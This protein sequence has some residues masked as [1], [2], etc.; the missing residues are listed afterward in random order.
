MKEAA[1]KLIGT[2]AAHMDPE[3]GEVRAK[4]KHGG[5]LK[6]DGPELLMVLSTSCKTG[7]VASPEGCPRMQ[8]SLLAM[9][10]EK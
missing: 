1:A 5:G 4:G 2:V 3:Q 6:E 9:D 7:A 10:A 8:P